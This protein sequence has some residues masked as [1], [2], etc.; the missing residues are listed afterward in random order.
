MSLQISHGYALGFRALRSVNVNAGISM[1]FD[2][3]TET[4]FTNCLTLSYI[5]T[6]AYLDTYSFNI[7]MTVSNPLN[8]SLIDFF[9]NSFLISSPN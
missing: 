8:Y 1:R 6:A 9:I 5:F 3:S 2:T 7:I 4:G